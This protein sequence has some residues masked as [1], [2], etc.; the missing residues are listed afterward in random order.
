MHL[1]H[2]QGGTQLL[3]LHYFKCKSR[4]KIMLHAMQACPPQRLTAVEPYH[5]KQRDERPQYLQRF[6]LARTTSLGGGAV[7]EGKR[8][9][10]VATLFALFVLICSMQV[11]GDLYGSFHGAKRSL[12]QLLAPK[13]AGDGH[14]YALSSD[15]AW[16]AHRP[17]FMEYTWTEAAEEVCVAA[18]Q[19]PQRL[20]S[21][22][23]CPRP[24]CP[25]R[26][27]ARAQSR[28]PRRPAPAR[29]R[30]R[31]SYPCRRRW[32]RPTSQWGPSPAPPAAQRGSAW[33]GGAT[34]ERAGPA[35]PAARPTGIA[36]WRWGPRCT[37]PRGW[38]RRWRRCRSCRPSR[39]GYTTH[40]AVGPHTRSLK[41]PRA[42]CAQVRGPPG[43][44]WALLPPGVGG[45]RWRPRPRCA[46]CP[47][48]SKELT[49]VCAT[50]TPPLASLCRCSQSTWAQSTS[51]AKW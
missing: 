2:R 34:C 17:H 51:R 9:T 49:G 16:H 29:L 6:S 44:L 38:M 40:S 48:C 28:A 5:W 1:Q 36:S 50:H 42:T 12:Q 7:M 20:L 23:A 8:V 22:A 15:C 47:C 45:V 18:G 4:S 14:T 24:P 25:A 37:P 19:A 39:S 32:R 43:R 21:S 31:I 10:A 11:M 33:S 46:A 27:A 26:A 30:C 13:A 41:I 35:P 3:E